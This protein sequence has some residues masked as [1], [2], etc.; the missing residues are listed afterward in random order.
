MADPVAASGAPGS[1]RLGVWIAAARPKTLWAAVAPVLLGVGLA[2][3]DGVFHPL[4][5]L[6]ALAG[7]VFIQIGTNYVND[8][9]DAIK[10]ADTADRKGPMRAVATGL[11]SPGAMRAAAGIAF[12][13]AFA[14]GGYL[15]ARGGV[16][17]LI[18]GLVCI[19][20][21]VAYTAGKY[22]L[23]YTGL[24]DLFVLVF[25]G[26]VAVAGTYYV[27]AL[28]L[29]SWVPIAGLGPGA[30][31]TAILLANNVRDVN[32]DRIA[33]KMTLVVRFG[34]NAGVALYSLMITVAVMVP[35]A[36]VW[37]SRGHLGALAA[38]AIASLAGRRLATVLARNEDPAVLNPLLGKTALLLLVYSLAFAL[39][40]WLT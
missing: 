38:S 23:A 19:A 35:A 16:E 28:A 6:C 7:A 17:I 5:A 3:G 26:P 18:L 30:L 9:E 13:L 4:A 27:Q 21:G 2:L 33:N 12:A 31:A 22:A 40:W 29:P 37:V 15:I 11:V 25:F 8:S 20:S 39:G 14:S 1:A 24:A 36:M 32:E 34:R 10:G